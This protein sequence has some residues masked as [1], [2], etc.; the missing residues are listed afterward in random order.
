MKIDV[1]GLPTP[2]GKQETRTFTDPDQPGVELT[3]T[4]KQLTFLQAGKLQERIAEL[5]KNYVVNNHPVIV[6]GEP[7]TLSQDSCATLAMLEVMHV[8]DEV[9]NRTELCGIMLKFPHAIVEIAEF[10]AE[11]NEGL[12]SK[13]LPAG[14]ASQ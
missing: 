1:M 14:G 11:I 6:G 12:G 10:I 13:N 2:A 9:Y 5:E 4:L 7:V 3:L 8:G